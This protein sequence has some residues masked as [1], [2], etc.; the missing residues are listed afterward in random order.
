M[1]PFTMDGFNNTSFGSTSGPGW[2]QTCDRPIMSRLPNS[3][4]GIEN[5]ELMETP[6][7]SLHTSLHIET[8]NSLK[9]VESY[10]TELQRIVKVLPDLSKHIPD[11]S[12]HIKVA[13]MA[14]VETHKDG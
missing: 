2:T 3:P 6:N 11:L 7:K 13:I 5:K 9:S 14:L 10:Y 12:K 4:K 1:S 8:E